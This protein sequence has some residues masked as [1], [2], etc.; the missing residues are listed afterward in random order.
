MRN[1]AIITMLV[2][3]TVATGQAP[4]SRPSLVRIIV[5]DKSGSMAGERIEQARKELIDM[6]QKLPPSPAHPLIVVLFN[7][8]AGPVR[9]FTDLPSCLTFLRSISADGGTSIAKGLERARQELLPYRDVRHLCVV[10]YT[11]GE[12]GDQAGILKQE[13]QLDQ[14]FSGRSK[15]GLQQ[16]V[17]F[18]KRWESANADLLVRI[19]KRG[20]AQVIDAGEMRIQPVT[21]N[22]S[23]SVAQTR[24]LK[25]QLRILE[26]EVL[27]LIDA[28][29]Q[30][31]DS[32]PPVKVFCRNQ[33][34][35]GDIAVQ[36]QPGAAKPTLLKIHLPVTA[37]M[38]AQRRADIDFE[39]LLATEP[40]L[41]KT[42][43]LPLLPVDRVRLPVT[44]PRD[45]FTLSAKASMIM[46]KPAY[47]SDAAAEKPA[48]PLQ[49]TIDVKSLP[50]LPWPDAVTLQF[51]PQA[52]LRLVN[53]NDTFTLKKPGVVPLAIIVEAP[54]PAK[55]GN[56]SPT[57]IKLGVT[58]A[59]IKLPPD[60]T[61]E[62]AEMLVVCEAALPAPAV[63]KLTTRTRSVSPARWLDVVQ[64]VAIFDADVEFKVDGPLQADA[65]IGVQC[66][67]GVRNIQFHPTKIATGTQ[68]VRLTVECELPPA[69]TKRLLNFPV[70]PPRT[71]NTI[72]IA[73]PAP[74]KLKI[75]GPAPLQLVLCQGGRLQQALQA[76]ACDKS[77][78]ATL[79]VTP[80][81]VGL[82][83][84]A[85]ADGLNAKIVCGPLV[86]LGGAPVL[87]V[88][89]AGDLAPKT[90][91]ATSTSFFLDSVVEEELTVT[92]AT[93]TAAVL[94]SKQRIVLRIEAPFKRLFF[95]L[96]ASL[97]A[98]LVL[99]LLFRMYSRLTT[100]R[101]ES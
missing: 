35:L 67:P 62:P 42:L 44:L 33:G 15:R 56:A 4:A 84:G 50:D 13:E 78:P 65:H 93:P 8:D 86:Q 59:P 37:A 51:K 55:T 40:S 77:E 12:D 5:L 32:M 23:F 100:T 28:K 87:G 63:T 54:A 91:A 3:Q 7:H 89:Q 83:D 82:A 45:L 88:N 69:P 76:V 30:G 36:L 22:P 94:G 19:I 10:L 101:E 6:A 48:F 68:I 96:A 75:V 25:D 58:I 49:I 52:G 20:N 47:W 79:C 24:W 41:A 61:L 64:G 26:I 81:L 70:L 71:P 99:F 38:T 73:A 34:A 97:S 11:D 21:F 66:P 98:V 53:G 57:K 14:L 39:L 1:L 29:G 17:V 9:T 31:K 85:R 74:I 90:A 43:V 60:M 18:A 80:V 46:A 16:S 95:Y 27:A 2:T 92:S 72:Q